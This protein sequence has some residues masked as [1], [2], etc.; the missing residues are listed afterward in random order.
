[1]KNS[2]SSSET[3]ATNAL[4]HSVT[5]QKHVQ[6]QQLELTFPFTLFIALGAAVAQAV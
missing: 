2:V 6:Y 3:S 5:G 1:M 4:L